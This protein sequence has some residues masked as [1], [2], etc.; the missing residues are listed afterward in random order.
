MDRADKQRWSN[1]HITINFNAG[2]AADV[3]RAR[4][5][6]EDLSNHA[7]LWTWLRYYNGDHQMVFP[8]EDRDLVERLRWRV[9]FENN[10]EHNH[11]LHAHILLEIQHRTCIQLNKFAIKRALADLGFEGANVNVRF[12]KGNADDK[13]W[14]LQYITK[15]MRENRPARFGNARLRDAMR[16]QTFDF[17]EHP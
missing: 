7:Y 14:I 16:G 11:N 10:G 3:R 15:S 17:T 2:A 6:I 13:D 1:F 12:M 4:A 8:H 5:A 9:G